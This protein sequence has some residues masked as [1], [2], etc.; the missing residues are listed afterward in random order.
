MF[1][2]D[3][4]NNRLFHDRATGTSERAVR[5]DVDALLF[6]EVDNL[7][8]GKRGVILDLVDSWDNSC[9]GQQLLQESQA[10]V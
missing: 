1:L 8:L 10:V 3:L 7:L 4:Y 5:G 2:R 9:V 6:A